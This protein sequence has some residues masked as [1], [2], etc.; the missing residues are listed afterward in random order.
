VLRDL[1]CGKVSVD[2]ARRGYG[3][4]IREPTEGP[5]PRFELDRAG[6]EQLR[7][8]LREERPA[9]RPF[10]DHGP[11][12]RGWPAAGPR[13]NATGSD[14]LIQRQVSSHSY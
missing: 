6:T 8:R 1:H 5:V 14:R 3:V 13:P 7:A 12:T 9:E 10:F 11:V 4:L 2:G